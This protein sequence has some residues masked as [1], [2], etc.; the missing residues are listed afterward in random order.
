MSAQPQESPVAL[1]SEP[2]ADDG[3][4]T[5]I[6]A[7]F[8][9]RVLE[10]V[11]DDEELSAFE[12]ESDDDLG[13]LP[14][15][16]ETA[17]DGGSPGGADA[18]EVAE[19]HPG[20]DSARLDA[21]ASDEELDAL[22]SDAAASTLPDEAAGLADQPS[23]APSR[24][25]KAAGLGGLLAAVPASLIALLDTVAV[26]EGVLTAIGSVMTLLGALAAAYLARDR[27]PAT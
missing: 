27:T 10:L 3:P 13:E 2:S 24:K 4:V 5:E 11:E 22:E 21:L 7:G 19:L 9:S 12:D 17:S 15:E 25:V 18:G 16:A 6:V 20:F 1:T 26:S 14:D 8:D 23:K